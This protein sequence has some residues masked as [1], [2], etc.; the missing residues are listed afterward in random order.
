MEVRYLKENFVSFCA[1]CFLSQITFEFRVV[2]P[3]RF[4][5]NLYF[6]A[7]LFFRMKSTLAILIK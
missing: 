5:E 3:T 7:L 1:Q 4:N 2:S 6:V